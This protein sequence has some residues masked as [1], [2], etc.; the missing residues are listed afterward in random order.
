M[1]V[2]VVA[3]VVAGP[4]AAGAQAPNTDEEARM[5]YRLGRAYHDSGRFLD[6]AREFE[7]SYRL[8]NRPELLYNIFVAYRDGGDNRNAARALRGYVEL[9]P[10]ADDISQLRARL[11]VMERNLANE[12]A[13]TTTPE[14]TTPP[15]EGT[16]PAP[17]PEIVARPTDS[18]VDTGPASPSSGG[19]FPLVPVIVMGAGGVL[20]L[21]SIGTGVA[22]LGAQSDLDEQ[23][24]EKEGT[25]RCDPA[26]DWESTRDSG[27]TMALVTDILWITGGLA[28]GAGVALLFLMDSGAETSPG[29]PMVSASCDGTG[30]AGSVRVPF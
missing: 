1:G 11:E 27:Q 20:A 16:E 25:R 7:E 8:S 22:A 19:E 26:S 30:C 10:N 12:P 14:G 17:T 5:H 4:M 18:P 24:P 13:A 15:T 29:A 2:V 21:A 28:V 3:C 23:C 9:V 6:A